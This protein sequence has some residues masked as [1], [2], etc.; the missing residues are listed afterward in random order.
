MWRVSVFGWLLVAGVVAACGRGPVVPPTATSIVVVAGTSPFGLATTP[1]PTAT[2]TTVPTAAEPVVAATATTSTTVNLP[3]VAGAPASATPRVAAGAPAASATRPAA[4]T[5][6]RMPGTFDDPALRPYRL[7]LSIQINAR[8]LEAVLQAAQAG[9]LAG[10]DLKVAALALAAMTQSIDAEL[11]GPL[12]PD[13]LAAAWPAATQAHEQVKAIAARWL[14][15]Q[16][17]AAAAAAELA[18]VQAGLER[19]LAAA[20]RVV[21]GVY[22]M[23]P[24]ALTDYRHKLVEA[25]ASAL[26]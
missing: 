25:S 15:G 4:A 11:P 8:L 22:G 3:M 5:G 2:P 23:A 26:E 10:D 12:P 1:A 20:D 13:T 24:G 16:I 18:P 9:Q 7:M 6:T 17:D 14:T 19:V 21:A